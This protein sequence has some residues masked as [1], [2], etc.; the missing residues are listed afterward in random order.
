MISSGCG[1]IGIPVEKQTVFTE[2]LVRYYESRFTKNKQGFTKKIARPTLT[3]ASI[4]DR[5]LPVIENLPQMRIFLR[6][7]HL[8]I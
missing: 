3:A 6:I 8:T 2:M 7:V 1:V 5:L 4:S